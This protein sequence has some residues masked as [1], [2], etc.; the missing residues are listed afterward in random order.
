MAT[1]KKIFI[2]VE[3]DWA[4]WQL[5]EWKRFV[6]D[7]PFSKLEHELKGKTVITKQAQMKELRATLKDYLS[8]LKEVNEM[9]RAEEIKKE[10]KGNSTI[11]PRMS[12][13]GN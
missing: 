6:D 10:A 3:L 11:P 9:R 13:D 12:Q 1:A 5:S 2:D 4:E 8:L 7:N